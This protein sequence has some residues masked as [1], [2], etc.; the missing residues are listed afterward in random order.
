MSL[1]YEQS[2]Y[3]SCHGVSGTEYPIGTLQHPVDNIEDAETICRLHG[4]YTID[5]QIISTGMD[6]PFINIDTEDMLLNHVDL[7]TK[8]ED[9]LYL[10]R[11]GIH[12]DSMEYS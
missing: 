7:T 8:N 3:I 4:V 5:H 6:I 2:V 10:E 9:D 1:M 12:Y 11:I